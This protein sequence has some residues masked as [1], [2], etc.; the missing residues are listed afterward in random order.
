MFLVQKSHWWI[1]VGARDVHPPNRNSFNFIQFL[2]K[3]AKIICWHPL[4]GWHSHVWEILDQPLKV[5][6]FECFE[7]NQR[8]GGVVEGTNTSIF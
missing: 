5:I 6:M 4:E 7:M 2:D 3:F 1:S 8:C